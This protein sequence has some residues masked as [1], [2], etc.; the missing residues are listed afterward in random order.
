MTLSEW[1]IRAEDALTG[2]LCPDSRVDA[3][4]IAAGALSKSPG[5][6]RFLGGMEI[7]ENVL[8]ILES[9]LQRR[10]KGEP[11]QYIENTA[12]FMDFEFYVDERVLIPRQDTETLVEFA[13][14]KIKNVKEPKILDICT[15]SGAIAVSL[16]AYRKDARVIASDISEDALIVS[17]INAQKTHADVTCIQSD[18]FDSIPD[19]KFDLITANP[20]Y[21]T[22]DDMNHL[23]TEVKA[24]PAL[25]LFGGEDGLD[26]YRRIS[27]GVYDYLN[28]GGYA[29]FEVG[30]GQASDVLS[31]MTSEKTTE[32]GI[33]KDLC[34]ID[35]VVWIRS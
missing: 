25:A 10:V 18:L 5:E 7:E 28:K 35:R 31:I 14:E 33:I 23:Q 19:Q 12:Y 27:K 24:E 34:G 4:L 8:E 17:R 32:K 26:L 30:E 3:K 21:L 16:S 29:L 1:L 2:A 13:L 6:I 9:R 15:G 11:L 22:K 20:P